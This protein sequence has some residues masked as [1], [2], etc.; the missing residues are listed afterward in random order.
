MSDKKKVI[1][2]GRQIGETEVKAT[3][4]ANIQLQ[5]GTQDG[6]AT[7]KSYQVE[8]IDDDTVNVKENPLLG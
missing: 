1:L 6:N 7:F 2:E 5:S 4:G 3:P 8:S